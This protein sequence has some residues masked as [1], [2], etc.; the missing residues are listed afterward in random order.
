MPANDNSLQKGPSEIAYIA[1]KYHLSELQPLVGVGWIGVRRKISAAF[2]NVAIVA[3]MPRKQSRIVKPFM[4]V[5]P[6]EQ[7]HD[8]H[9]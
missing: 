2:V 9:G 8:V 6:S 4:E 1:V 7:D 3:L 5:T